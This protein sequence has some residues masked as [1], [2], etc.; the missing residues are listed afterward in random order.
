[1]TA[2]GAALSMRREVTAVEFV[3][4]ATPSVAIG[5]EVVDAVGDGCPC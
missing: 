1:M 4:L 2:V 3:T 5:A